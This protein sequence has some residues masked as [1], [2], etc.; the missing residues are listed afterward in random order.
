[1]VVEEPGQIGE[2]PPAVTVGYGVM[3]TEACVLQPLAPSVTVYIV[4]EPGFAVTVAP[5]VALN[6]VPGDHV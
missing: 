4:D 3:V 2:P 1:M 5:V 6:P